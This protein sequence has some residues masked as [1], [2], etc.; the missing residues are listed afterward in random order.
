MSTDF[1]SPKAMARLFELVPKINGLKEGHLSFTD[2]NK[3]SLERLKQTFSDF[4]YTIFGLQDESE[5][6]AGG[7]DSMDG[8]MQLVIDIRKSARE[9]KDWGTSDKIRDALA[10][11]E[12]Q[13]KDGKEGTSWSKI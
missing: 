2:L 4:I 3:D 6:S 9:N 8:V 12:I 13:L 1:N 11:L 7:N 10:E 5:N